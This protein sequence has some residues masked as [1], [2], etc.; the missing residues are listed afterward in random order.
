MNYWVLGTLLFLGIS[1]VLMYF[2][3]YNVPVQTI[4]EETRQISGVL[5][6]KYQSSGNVFVII[7]HD[8]FTVVRNV[9][10]KQYN[11]YDVGENVCF[12]I[13][14][15]DEYVFFCSDL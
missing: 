14:D 6:D 2:I 7:D 5:Y 12:I 9:S 3:F 8:G 11:L 13:N 4:P 1:S 10:K 15:N